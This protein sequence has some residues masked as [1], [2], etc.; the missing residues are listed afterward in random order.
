[1][2]KTKAQLTEENEC[3]YDLVVSLDAHRMCDSNSKLNFREQ[4][5]RSKKNI[6]YMLKA[7]K[8]TKG[9]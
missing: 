4:Y 3:L 9:S 2:S 7:F 1:M 6:N 8:P 5:E